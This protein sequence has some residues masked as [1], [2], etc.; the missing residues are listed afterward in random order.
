VPSGRHHHLDASANESGGDSGSS[1][2]GG[3]LAK[4]TGWWQ[5]L[6]VKIHHLLV[7]AGEQLLEW[8]VVGFLWLLQL[9]MVPLRAVFGSWYQGNR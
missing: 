8:L 5:S 7:V 4:A 2:G 1:E 9:L 3:V 6:Q